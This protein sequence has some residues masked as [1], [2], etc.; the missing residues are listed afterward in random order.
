MQ[1]LVPVLL[2]TDIYGMARAV[3][4]EFLAQRAR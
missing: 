1:D 3:L 4:D 2:L